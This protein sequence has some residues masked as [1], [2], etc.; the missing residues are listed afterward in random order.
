[1]SLEKLRLWVRP[2]LLNRNYGYMNRLSIYL[3]LKDASNTTGETENLIELNYQHNFHCIINPSY[4]TWGLLIYVQLLLI[5][6]SSLVYLT[7]LKLHNYC[8]NTADD[9][10]SQLINS[11][12][13]QSFQRRKTVQGYI[14][15][16]HYLHISWAIIL[17]ETLLACKK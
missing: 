11:R 7:P 6:L 3:S 2:Y 5:P 9:T 16:I 17:T 15:W 8:Q 4:H 12:L 14:K 1:M 13:Q 10:V